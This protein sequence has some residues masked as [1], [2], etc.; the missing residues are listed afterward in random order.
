M[1]IL[2]KRGAFVGPRGPILSNLANLSFSGYSGRNVDVVADV[3][4]DWPWGCV[5]HRLLPTSLSGLVQIRRAWKSSSRESK[6]QFT[7]TRGCS[8]GLCTW[9][10]I[11]DLHAAFLRHTRPDVDKCETLQ[12]IFSSRG[13]ERYRLLNAFSYV[14]IL[15]PHHPALQS[16]ERHALFHVS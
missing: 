1:T 15:F 8:R 5:C 16:C 10:T 6:G 2:Q 3:Q 9:G 13:A 12:H 7:S 4:S 11:A 14:F